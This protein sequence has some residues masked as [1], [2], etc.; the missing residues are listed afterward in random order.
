MPHES[1]WMKSTI[2]VIVTYGRQGSIKN[3]KK[4]IFFGLEIPIWTNMEK[5]THAKLQIGISLLEMTYYATF[6]SL[7]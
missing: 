1:E 2:T 5:L 4:C 6:V 7:N 3:S